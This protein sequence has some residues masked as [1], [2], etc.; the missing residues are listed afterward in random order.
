MAETHDSEPG[1]ALVEAGTGPEFVMRCLFWWVVILGGLAVVGYLAAFINS[2]YLGLGYPYNTFLFIPQVRFSDFTIYY[3]RFTHFGTSQFWGSG[4]AGPVTVSTWPFTYPAPAAYI[5]LLFFRLVPHNP[6]LAA[7]AYDATV[8]AVSVVATALLATSVRRSRLAWPSTAVLLLTLVTSY[9][10]MLVID[11]ANTE[12]GAW[13]FAILGAWAFVRGRPRIAAILFGLAAS[14]KLAPLALI[15]LF[16]RTRNWKASALFVGTF[17]VTNILAMWLMA[18]GFF[19][20]SRHILRGLLFF[21]R[22]YVLGF[23]GTEIG[24]DHSLFSICKQ[25]TAWICYGLGGSLNDVLAMASVS[26]YFYCAAWLA[27][28]MALIWRFR[29]LPVLNC[30]FGTVVVELIAPPVSGDGTLL[31]LYFPWAVFVLVFLLQDVYSGRV[32]FPLSKVLAIL[33]PCAIAFTP[34]ECYLLLPFG[35]GFAGQVKALALAYLLYFVMKNPLPC[36]TF[37][38]MPAANGGTMPTRSACMVQANI[39]QQVSGAS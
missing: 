34:Q 3:W 18:P 13:F 23:R 14:I 2:Q 30:I 21:E 35:V 16:L 20:V 27:A 5:Y 37:G 19:Q 36:K 25:V 9:P 39:G 31:Y 4:S 22:T 1:R 32:S 11:R 12:G 28:G 15:F 6:T 10:L 38:E 7:K 24:F 33:V 29:K 8:A 17:L 26:Y